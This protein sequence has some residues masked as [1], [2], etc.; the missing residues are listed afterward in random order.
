MRLPK[1]YP[2]TNT[3]IS[4][5][6]HLEQVEKL[7]SG[8]ADFIQ[9]REKTALSSE[10]Y[11]SAKECVSARSSVTKILIND[12]VDIALAVNADGVHLGQNDLSPIAAR[13]LLGDMAIIGF[14]THTVKQALDAV[15]LPI[16]YI[17]IGPVFST[18]TKENANDIVGII[19]VQ[20]VRQI[21]GDFPLVAIGGINAEN[22]R[23]V[24]EAGADSVA[25]ISAL[26]SEPNQ[27]ENTF[28]KLTSVEN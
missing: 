8:G 16:D 21:I 26:L 22:Y 15:N 1:I 11:E 14:S 9:I 6:S 12:R 18:E 25:M 7:I 10:F 23:D 20:E 3:K 27:I 28:K 24:L 19:G 5:L 13:K 17:A 4:G 2:I